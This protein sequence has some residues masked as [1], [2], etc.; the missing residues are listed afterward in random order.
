MKNGELKQLT[1]LVN[2]IVQSENTAR[3]EQGNSIN[4]I[5]K[6][7]KVKVYHDKRKGYIDNTDERWYRENKNIFRVEQRIW[8]I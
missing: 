7:M 6:E 3:M 5:Q 2:E 1:K 8:L 4:R